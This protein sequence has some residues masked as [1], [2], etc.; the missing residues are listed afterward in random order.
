MLDR[1]GDGMATLIEEHKATPAERLELRKQLSECRVCAWLSTLDEKTRKDWAQ[2]L[3]NPRY[4]HSAVA[5][6]ISADQ[7]A[8]GY[9]GPDVGE[10][11]V[12]THRRRGHR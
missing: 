10:S 8:A 3:G 5:A 1:K 6:E 2:A 9:V 11:S 4:G 12:D 7:G